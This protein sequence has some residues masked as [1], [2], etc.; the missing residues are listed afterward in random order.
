[1]VFQNKF[2]PRAANPLAATAPAIAAKLQ[3]AQSEVAELEAQH[4]DAA[5]AAINGE[6]GAEDRLVAFDSKLKTARAHVATLQAAH[7]AAIKRDQ[8]VLAEQRASL[9][10]T[11]INA[12][13]KHIERRNREAEQLSA[14]I[15]E[16]ASHYHAL[17]DATVKARGV[18][19]IGSQWP[20]SYFDFGP[21]AIRR[22]VAQEMFR[23]SASAGAA[24]ALPGAHCGEARYEHQPS[25]MPQLVER[26]K[27]ASGYIF[28]TLSGKDGK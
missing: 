16:L 5:L 7:A 6:P 10:K 22:L 21:D 27:E 9:R 12:L 18:V 14:A 8:S 26:V 2:P 13:R 11:Q 24:N 20:E 23:L 4:G 1:M 17:L 3:A 28:K 15:V 25:A 19:P